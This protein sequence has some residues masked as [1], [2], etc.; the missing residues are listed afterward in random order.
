MR[1]KYRVKSK[2]RFRTTIIIV[3][4]IFVAAILTTGQVKAYLSSK[5][6][7]VK[8]YVSQGDT[9]WSISSRTVPH[10]DRRKHVYSISKLNHLENSN[11]YP[12]QAL[13]VPIS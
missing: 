10:A 4:L 9:L 7:Y 2:V 1:I 11:I 13:L 5:N 8:V 6:E 3:G 12:G